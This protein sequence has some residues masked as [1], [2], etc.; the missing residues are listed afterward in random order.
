MSIVT[1]IFALIALTLLLVAGGVLFSGLQLRQNRIAELRS[2][3]VQLARIAELDM[4][5]IL[6]GT[7]QLLATLAKLPIDHGWDAR[8]CSVMAATANSDFEYDHL[9]AVDRDGVRQCSSTVS[10][11]GGPLVSYRGLFHRFVRDRPDVRRRSVSCRLSGGRR[12]RHRGRR[13]LRR[14]Q[15]GMVEYRD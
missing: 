13:R 14:N 8:A 10:M 9:T 5:R 12:H 6:E 1:R 15:L 3:T 4:V 11:L 2:D 7:H